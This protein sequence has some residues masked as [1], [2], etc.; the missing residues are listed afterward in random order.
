MRL[1]WSMFVVLLKFLVELGLASGAVLLLLFMSLQFPRV[2]ETIWW[3]FAGFVGL[4]WFII[5]ALVA[6]DRIEEKRR[7][8]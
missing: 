4:M 8:P 3:V 5:W 2:A 6:Q 1:L 7:G